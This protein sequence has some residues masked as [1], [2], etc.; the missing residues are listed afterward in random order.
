MFT[1]QFGD[2]D[3]VGVAFQ[4]EAAQALPAVLVGEIEVP[5][6]V[7]G[8]RLLHVQLLSVLLVEEAHFLQ[9]GHVHC[10]TQMQFNISSMKTRYGSLSC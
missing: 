3:G 9:A 1:G 8:G 2:L 7:L 6:Q 4:A 5:H 10:H